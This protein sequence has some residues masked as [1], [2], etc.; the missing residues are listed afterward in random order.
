MLLDDAVEELRTAIDELRSLASG[1]TPELLA[2]GGL[3]AAVDDFVGRMPVP[4]RL[5]GPARL[6]PG[7]EAVAYFVISEAVT[8]R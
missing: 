6:D 2:R 5:T 7:L 3:R 8:T 1:A 4:V